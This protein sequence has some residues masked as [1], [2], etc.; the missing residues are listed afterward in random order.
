M[1]DLT[2][3]DADGTVH[4]IQTSDE[5]VNYGDVHPRDHGGL[6][7]RF[8]GRA[9][10]LIATRPPAALPDGITETEHMVEEAAVWPDD[11]FVD[12]DPDQGPTDFLADRIDELYGT[13]SYEQ[14]VVE[15]TVGYYVAEW[16]RYYGG[17][18]TDMVPDAQYTEYLNSR[19]IDA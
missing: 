16:I 12:G 3:T 8:D 11:L 13:E 9:W 14:V 7:V 2:Y 15:E 1:T 10:E 4:D 5:W 6:F 19:G 18:D 17:H